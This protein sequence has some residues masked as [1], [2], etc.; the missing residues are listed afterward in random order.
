MNLGAFQP[1]NALNSISLYLNGLKTI[2]NG[3]RQGLESSEEII[4]SNNLLLDL[5]EEMW[6]GA[7]KVK[8]LDLRVNRIETIP[9]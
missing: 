7:K 9:T 4:I 3:T 8:K 2:A 5:R 6:E 1:L